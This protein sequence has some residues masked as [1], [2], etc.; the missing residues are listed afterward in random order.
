MK[1]IK[2][3]SIY[4]CKLL[5]H[6]SEET[7]SCGTEVLLNAAIES[8]REKSRL[9]LLATMRRLDWS[10]AASAA[11]CWRRPLW[12]KRRVNS[13]EWHWSLT[14]DR[15]R[16]RFCHAVVVA[17]IVWR[18]RRRRQ[19]SARDLAAA[20]ELTAKIDWMRHECERS[21]L[22]AH[23]YRSMIISAG[24]AIARWSTTHVPV[25]TISRWSLP[26]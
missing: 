22:R 16:A 9:A 11:G 12:S 19:D 26:R 13:P 18:R 14:T 5:K 25:Q 23:A 24:D 3:F 10:W 2:T 7:E 17:V 6:S 20:G 1:W 15:L 4:V 8:Q 21:V